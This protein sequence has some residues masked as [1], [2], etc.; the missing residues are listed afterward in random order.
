MLNFAF[1]E[2]RNIYL[3]TRRDNHVKLTQEQVL[4]EAKETELINLQSLEK[5]QQLELEK[6]KTRSVKK[7]PTGPTI[8]Y[9]STIM[10]LV[11]DVTFDNER[12]INVEEDIKM[13]EA[14]VAE[15]IIDS[16]QRCERTFVT[17]ST[18]KD[19]DH[20]FKKTKETPPQKNICPITRFDRY[21]LTSGNVTQ[22]IKLGI[23]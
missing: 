5:Y 19:F 20:V 9:L 23:P 13:D 16:K 17:F 12:S 18:D 11:E 7:A 4:E 3:S 8:Q 14:P 2:F 6:K 10:P 21:C 15:F 1:Q 22:I